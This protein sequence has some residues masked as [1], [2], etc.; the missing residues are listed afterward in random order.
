VIRPPAIG[1][2]LLSV[3]ESSIASVPG[4]RV[5]RLGSFLGV[6]AETEWNAV[7]AARQL[8]ATWSA[9]AGLPDHATLFNAARATALERDETIA[10][11][12]DL[13]GLASEGGRGLTATY[14]WPIQTHGS[15]GPSCAV[16]D[17]RPDRAT[18]WTASQATH[19][20]QPAFAQILGLPRH[21]IRVGQP[22]GSA[23][24]GGGRSSLDAGA[25]RPCECGLRRDGSASS[26]R[27]IPARPRE[28]GTQW[29]S[30]VHDKRLNG[31]MGLHASARCANV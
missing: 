14:Q 10:K 3:D 7:R 13:S 24:D 2:K 1:A 29:V 26:H 16:A 31:G 27:A 15:I 18:I 9:W 30:E 17:V 21:R 12:G 4:V 6:A 11:R 28:S 25:S 22:P 20:F 8:K 19:K 5:V 23:A